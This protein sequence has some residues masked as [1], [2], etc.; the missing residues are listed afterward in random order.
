MSHPINKI[1]GGDIYQN[2]ILGGDWKNWNPRGKGWWEVN[3]LRERGEGV[4]IKRVD[5]SPPALFNR[6][7]LTLLQKYDYISANIIENLVL[8]IFKL[9]LK[10][11]SIMF[12]C[13]L[14][15]I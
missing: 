5:L 13:I 9:A 10:L 6:M 4:L 3:L 15:S 2:K 1:G 14:I 8:I 12:S 11:V 7:S